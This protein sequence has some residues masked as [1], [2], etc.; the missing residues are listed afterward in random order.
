MV[1]AAVM[2]LGIVTCRRNAARLAMGKDDGEENVSSHGNVNRNMNSVPSSQHPTEGTHS[3]PGDFVS[4][5]MSLY[6]FETDV[7]MQDIQEESIY[8]PPTSLVSFA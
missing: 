8:E 6:E 3:G 7:G 5:D 2:V 4:M 1:A